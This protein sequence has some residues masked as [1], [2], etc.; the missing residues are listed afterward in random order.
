MQ[1]VILVILIVSHNIGEVQSLSVNT[2]IINDNC[3]ATRASSLLEG[4]E[5]MDFI[6]HPLPLPYTWTT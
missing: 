6:V 3:S 2:S 1:I 5:P 4:H